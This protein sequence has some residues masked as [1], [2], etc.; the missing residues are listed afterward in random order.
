MHHASQT[1]GMRKLHTCHADSGFSLAELLVVVSIA[2]L[3]LVGSVPSLGKWQ[4]SKRAHATLVAIADDIAHARRRAHHS[5]APVVVCP[6]SDGAR[7]DQTLDYS[8]GW[9]VFHNTN[10]DRPAIRDPDE[11]ILLRG[12]PES[13]VQLVANRRR[14]ELTAHPRR[15]T[16]GTITACD[17]AARV[18][19]KR[20]VVSYSGRARF[21]TS[22]RSQ[23]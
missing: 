16:N 12:V 4:A 9:L 7:C 5:P 19:A 2:A 1:V 20:L 13:G 8:D 3:L 23:C 22:D 6:S 10:E 17:R 14:F 18:P 11:P 15:S 21:A